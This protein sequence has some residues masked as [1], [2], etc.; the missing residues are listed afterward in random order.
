MMRSSRPS[1]AGAFA[2]AGLALPLVL[3]IVALGGCAA[4]P[5][6]TVSDAWVRVSLPEQPRVLGYLTLT[7]DREADLVA[8]ETPLAEGVEF[9]QWREVNH[10]EQ[11]VKVER[12]PVPANRPLVFGPGTY[13]LWLLNPPKQFM[14]GEKV[15]LALTFRAGSAETRVEAE[16]A[17]RRPLPS[18]FSAT[19]GLLLP[20][21]AAPPRLPGLP[22][23]LSSPAGAPPRGGPRGPALPPQPPS[24]PGF[25]QDPP[26]ARP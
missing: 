14:L 17:V 3:S 23:D 22:P 11:L 10:L 4:A 26:P 25:P 6:V 24:A 21:G 9:A 2:R 1:A 12:I 13:Q 20:G 19:P 15:P 5:R 7:S 18:G 8:V 16:A